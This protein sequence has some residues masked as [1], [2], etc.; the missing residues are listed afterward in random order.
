MLH[1]LLK[2]KKV[3]ACLATAMCLALL[4]CPMQAKAAENLEVTVM[5]PTNP[6][7]IFTGD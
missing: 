5:S 4:L 2:F 6:D 3:F 1:S 7:H